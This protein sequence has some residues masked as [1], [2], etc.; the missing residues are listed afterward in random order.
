[1]IA[2]VFD[3]ET[4]GLVNNRTLRLDR[5]PEIIEQRRFA[6]LRRDNERRNA[7]HAGAV[8]AVELQHD[9]IGDA[10]ERQQPAREVGERRALAGDLDQIGVAAA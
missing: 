4:T 5:Q 3:T 7:P 8:L 2:L 9:R 1:M 10:G 6:A